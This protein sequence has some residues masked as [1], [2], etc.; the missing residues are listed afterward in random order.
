MWL[1]GRIDI[2]GDDW[3]AVIGVI[4]DWGNVPVHAEILAE[5]RVVRLARFPALGGK[6]RYMKIV[7]RRAREGNVR[8]V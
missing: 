2:G 7:R 3:R 8:C 6:S 5:N 4:G 1:C